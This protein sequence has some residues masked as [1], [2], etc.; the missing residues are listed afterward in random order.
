MLIAIPMS[1]VVMG[2]TMIT[3]AVKS[4]DGLVIDDYYKHGKE[5][6]RQFA[7]DRAAVARGLEGVLAIDPAQRRVTVDVSAH[8]L[9]RLP[10]ALRLQL[11]H[12]TRAGLDQDLLLIQT[13]PGQ[14]QALLAA[15]PPPG[16]WRIQISG[17]DWRIVGRIQLP[18]GDSARVAPAIAEPASALAADRSA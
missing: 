14:Y 9:E 2:I 17:E 10:R 4:D 3:L 5:I 15:D 7:R 12:P 16:H 13:R 18:A 6:N 1:A 11:L 8:D